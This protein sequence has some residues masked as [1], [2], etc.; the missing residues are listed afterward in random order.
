MRR[1]RGQEQLM[2][3]VKREGAEGED[4]MCTRHK[5]HWVCSRKMQGCP[6]STLTISVTL[7]KSCLLSEQPQFL[8]P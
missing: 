3:A 5:N 8:H 7:A 4:R 1:G 2:E 6:D